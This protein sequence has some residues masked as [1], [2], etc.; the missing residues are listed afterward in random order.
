MTRYGGRMG[1]FRFRRLDMAKLIDFAYGSKN[2][3]VI[4]EYE[5][6]EWIFD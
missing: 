5:H 4:R 2:C 6:I 1:R 3:T